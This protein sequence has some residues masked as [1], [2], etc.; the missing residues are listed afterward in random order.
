MAGLLSTSA[1]FSEQGHGVYARC[2][3]MKWPGPV[4]GFLHTA[5]SPTWGTGIP[6]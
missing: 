5:S 2:L 6:D 4:S 3:C 1:G